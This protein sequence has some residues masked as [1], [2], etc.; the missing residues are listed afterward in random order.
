MKHPFAF[1]LLSATVLSAC[2]NSP[3]DRIRGEWNVVSY[4]ETRPGAASATVENIGTMTFGK[5]G[6]GTRDISYSFMGTPYTDGNAFSWTATENSVRITGPEGKFT[7]AWIIQKGNRDE[8][9]WRSTDGAGNV[10][11]MRLEKK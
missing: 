4:S 11:E 10:Q 3:E 9:V 8:Q 5:D 6:Q 7:K 2:S 1:A